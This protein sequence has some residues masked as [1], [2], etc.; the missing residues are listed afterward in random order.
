MYKDI[1]NIYDLFVKK[2]NENPDK[3]FIISLFQANEEIISY[4]EFFKRTNFVREYF[5]EIGLNK[6]DR[7]NIIIQKV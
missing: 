6:G 4:N 2:T 7:I 3:E 5:Q 1:N